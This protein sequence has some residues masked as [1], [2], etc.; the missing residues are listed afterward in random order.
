MNAPIQRSFFDEDLTIAERFDLWKATPGGGQIMRRL[1]EVAAGCFADHRRY[2][3]PASQRFVWETVR[4]R[5]DRVA[6][7]LAKS[8]RRLER[9]RGFCMNDH[10]TKHWALH[11]V[12]EHPDWAVLFSFREPVERVVERKQIVIHT[13]RVIKNERP[14]AMAVE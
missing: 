14:L 3:I 2:G 8:G 10:F 11:A 5:L 1:Y 7:R 4:R 9:E 13:E 12:A 6:G